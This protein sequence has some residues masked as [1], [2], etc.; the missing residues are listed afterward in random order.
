MAMPQVSYGALPAAAA[1]LPANAA[2]QSALERILSQDVPWE[3]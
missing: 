3:T 2:D 1:A